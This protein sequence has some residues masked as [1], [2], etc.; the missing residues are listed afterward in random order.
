M[1]KGNLQGPIP[2]AQRRPE[3]PPKLHLVNDPSPL[4]IVLSKAILA[5]PRLFKAPLVHFLVLKELHDCWCCAPAN[6]LYTGTCQI[7]GDNSKNAERLS[8]AICRGDK[9]NCQTQTATCRAAWLL[10]GSEH[11]RRYA[12]LGEA[13]NQANWHQMYVSLVMWTEQDVAC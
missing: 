2:S 4:S 3:V 11:S 6:G 8:G 7:E 13:R 9:P 10:N 1:D 12:A 5:V